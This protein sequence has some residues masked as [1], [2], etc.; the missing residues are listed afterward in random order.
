[1]IETLEN[2]RNDQS[3]E[4]VRNK[5]NH[6]VAEVVEIIEKEDLS[7]SMKKVRVPRASRQ[8]EGDVEG[9]LRVNNY[10]QCIDKI[11]GELHQRF[12]DES[13]SILN[14]LAMICFDQKVE[15]EVFQKVGNH[16]D[17]STEQLISEHQMF[18]VF[19]VTKNNQAY[20]PFN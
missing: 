17:L 3:F 16:Y 1:M 15:K 14:N 2:L 5:S 18:Q 4:D 6:Q 12:D 10:F 9:Y 7:C 19:K 11:T 20:N 13:K 8:W